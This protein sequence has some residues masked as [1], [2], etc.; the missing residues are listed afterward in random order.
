M[1]KQCWN[2]SVLDALKRLSNPDGIVTR[3]ALIERELP[4]IIEETNSSGKTPEQT[5]S[6]VLQ[7]PRNKGLVEFL[8]HGRYRLI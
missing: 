7:Q 6:Y 8:G 3:Q 1:M 5:L 4:T 2:D